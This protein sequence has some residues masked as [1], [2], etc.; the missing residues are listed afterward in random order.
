MLK[1]ILFGGLAILVLALTA[2]A[3]WFRAH[4]PPNCTD[5]RTLA[6]VRRSLTT[7]YQ[8]PPA[9]TLVNI[10]TVAGGWLALR[11]VCAADLAGF[12]PHA[13]APGAPIPGQIRYTSR[14]TPDRSRHEVTVELHPV[15][16]WEPAE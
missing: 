1:A 4:L 5:P 2:S 14:L 16:V 8:L 15:M 11:F 7:R 13:L 10:R 6:L 9:T 12:D 3:A